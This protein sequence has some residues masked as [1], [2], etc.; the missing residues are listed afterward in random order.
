VERIVRRDFP[1]VR[2][3]DV[4]AILAGYSS[5]W[6]SA[7]ARVQLAALKLSSGDLNSLRKHISAAQQDPRDV[8]VA[9][10]YSEYW[11]ATY[12]SSKLSKQEHQR[13]VEADWRQYEAWLRK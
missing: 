10:E 3:E 6:K 5:H 7:D 2:F 1:G 12:R 9:A 11:K 4:M 13:L 8:L